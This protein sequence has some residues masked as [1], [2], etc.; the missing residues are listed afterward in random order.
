MK[1]KFKPLLQLGA[2]I[3]TA[4]VLACTASVSNED[5]P[6]VSTEPSEQQAEQ[7]ATDTTDTLLEINTANR[8]VA[9][10]SLSAD[11]TANLSADRLVGI[12]GSRILQQDSRFADI[13]TVSQDRTEPD[14]EKIVELQ[15]DLVMGAKG[16]HDKAL[17]KL[18]DLDIPVL[19]VEINSWENL[20]EL[21][22]AL[23]VALEADPQPLL[24]RYDACLSLPAVENAATDGPSTL[25]LVSRQPILAPNNNSWAGDFL[26]QFNIQNLAAD[27]Q[28]ESAID[29]YVTLSAEKV[30]ETN[31]DNVMVVDT[32]ND[33]LEQLKSEPFWSQLKATEDG[34]VY[35]FDYF[36]LIN[37]GSI[38]S[39]EETCA[40]LKEQVSK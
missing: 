39:I 1:I 9:L 10:T 32:G 35:S 37:P 7:P 18:A 22:T 2:V 14:L 28:G 24:D 13:Q 30:I 34:S 40:Q 29:G 15:P 27:L 11:L 5:S 16:F 21:T 26:E 25:V 33:L 17:Q 3:S 23:A 31:P 6:T 8:V 19:T 38:A 36:G 20:R 4:T 12:P